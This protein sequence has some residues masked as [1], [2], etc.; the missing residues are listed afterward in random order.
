MLAAACM[1]MLWSKLCML[2]APSRSCMQMDDLAD[3]LGGRNRKGG[4]RWQLIFTAGDAHTHSELSQLQDVT[5]SVRW[6]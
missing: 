4:K 5:R 6:C 1:W 3:V 2:R